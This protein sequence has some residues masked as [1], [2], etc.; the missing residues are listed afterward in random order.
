MDPL[1]RGSLKN[2]I[3]SAAIDRSRAQRALDTAT[4]QAKPEH[5]LQSLQNLVNEADARLS[6]AALALDA[7]TPN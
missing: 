6:M 2:R 4:E 3:V 7:I 5:V 1:D